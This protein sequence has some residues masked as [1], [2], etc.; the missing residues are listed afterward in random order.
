[1]KHNIRKTIG[2]FLIASLLLIR[3]ADIGAWSS[4]RNENGSDHAN[5]IFAKTPTNPE[6]TGA[7]WQK[8]FVETSA[9]AYDSV[10]IITGSN[11]YIVCKNV[12][13]ELDMDGNILSSLTLAKSMNSICNMS[14]Y[15]NKLFIPLSG[16]TMQCVSTGNLSSLWIS[17]E[18]GLQSLTTTYC[19]DGF[20]YAGTTNA[21]GSDG[22]YYCLDASDGKTIWTYKNESAPCGF[23]WSGAISA[24]RSAESSDT[25]IPAR[26]LLF[27]GDNGILVS[28]SRTEDI[29]YDTFHLSDITGSSGSI[30]A[31]ITYDS[32]TDAYYTT[33]NNGYL[34]KIK[35]NTNGCFHSV[36]SVFLGDMPSASVNCTSTPTIYNNRIYVC[37]YYNSQGLISVIDAVSLKQIYSVTCDGFKDIKSS[38]LVS[39]GY[40]TETNN[41][42]VYVYFTQN[43]APGGIYYIEDD[44]EACSSEIKTLFLPE[45]GKQFCMSSIAAGSDGTLYYSNDSGTLFAVNEGY[46]QKNS[47]APSA[48]AM[49]P[50][51]A[52][53]TA[54]TEIPSSGTQKTDTKR[55]AI[56]TR[57]PE[58]PTKIKYKIKQKKNK[59]FK[60]TFTWKKGRYSKKTL[61]KIPGKKKILLSGKKRSIL[62]KKGKYTIRFYGYCSSTR[63]S[64]PA[65]IKIKLK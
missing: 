1:M 26:P 21:D 17:E 62:L 15:E 46:A 10:P 65:K 50:S 24:S 34:Y 20:V 48:S 51:S 39:T 23:Y 14:L 60:I 25:E 61:I 6:T 31:G 58:K 45:T 35:I 38:P 28:H 19:Q 16:G 9:T 49:P 29:V 36:E 57:R 5:T 54:S 7:K 8:K 4:F 47:P 64:S 40:A 43:F 32:V 27:G 3:F 55:S 63:K 18:F 2:L 59:K 53:P 41:D 42:K 44:S 22:L 52:V 37:S 11:I 12:L 56:N 13:Y 33:T 30:R